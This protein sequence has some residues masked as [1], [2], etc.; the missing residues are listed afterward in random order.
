MFY[1][2]QCYFLYFIYIK[3]IYLLFCNWLKL[4]AFAQRYVQCNPGRDG[5]TQDAVRL[6]IYFLF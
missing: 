4:K 3:F 5:V 1:L 2:N 6:S